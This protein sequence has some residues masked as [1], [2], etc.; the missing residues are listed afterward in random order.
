LDLCSRVTVLRDGRMIASEHAAEMSRQSIVELMLGKVAERSKVERRDNKAREGLVVI[1]RLSVPGHVTDFELRAGGGEIVAIAGQVGSGASEVPRALAGQMPDAR[2]HVSIAGR[3]MRLGQRLAGLIGVDRKRLGAVVETLSG[4]N[5]RKVFLGRCL[6]KEGVT[7]LMFDEPTRVD[8]GGRRYSQ[9]HP[10]R[11]IDGRPRH[12][13]IDRTRRDR[14]FG[15]HWATPG[16]LSIS[17]LSAI[18]ASAAFVGIIAGRF[19]ADH[20]ILVGGS[21]VT[22]GWGPVGR[23]VIG[24][25]IIATVTDMLPLVGASTGM[26][27][28][29]K[30]LIVAVVVVLIHLSRRERRSPCA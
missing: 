9:P 10:Q 30:S 19:D 26:Q 22:D 4:G 2:G 29:V 24:A 7:L 28:L 11:C 3:P 18:L 13:R 25:L 8:F 1:D 16:F 12:L 6:E 14:G 15:Q 23:T 17:N 21:A 27:I 20:A 5:Q